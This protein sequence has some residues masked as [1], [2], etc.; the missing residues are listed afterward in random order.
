MGV[1]WD[2]WRSGGCDVTRL[3]KRAAD[4][5]LDIST[6]S[7]ST[8]TCIFI[9]LLHSTSSPSLLLVSFPTPPTIPFLPTNNPLSYDLITYLSTC[10][11]PPLLPTMPSA[12]K[13]PR[14]ILE[15]TGLLTLYAA[16][17]D[18]KLLCLQRLV[19][20]FAYGGSTL[21][22]V[23]FLDELAISKTRTGLFMS[24]TLVGD[25]LISFV[26]TM[27][28]DGVGRKVVLAGG[29]GLMAASGVVFAT[30]GNFWVLLAAAILGV[31]SPR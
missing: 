27:F 18:T 26:L 4:L 30:C 16:P 15:E 6:T 3:E 23:A 13:L 17:L 28:A 19:R 22:L 5:D 24:L 14:L 9:L 29:A 12:A 8:S 25:T 1:E 31:I 10:Y 7:T 2:L 11:L 21:I 20:L